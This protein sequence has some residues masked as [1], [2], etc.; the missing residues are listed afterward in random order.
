[1]NFEK[2]EI[3]CQ[4]GYQDNKQP[5]AFTHK[6]YHREILEILDRWYDGGLAAG[7]YPKIDY[8]KVRT[9]DGHVF[10]L[11]YLSLFNSWSIYI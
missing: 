11:R 2:I 8:L 10:I 9:S 7:Y 6:G 5:A 4:S 3:E 1:M